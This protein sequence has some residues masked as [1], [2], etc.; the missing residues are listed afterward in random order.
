MFLSDKTISWDE[1]IAIGNAI[2]ANHFIDF[3]DIDSLLSFGETKARL[4]YLQSFL[5]VRYLISMYGPEIIHTILRSVAAGDSFHNVFIQT[6]GRDLID[7]EYDVYQEISENYR[8]M[9]VLQF[10]NIF[11]I[12]MVLLVLFVFIVIKLRNRKKIKGW[13]LVEEE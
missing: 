11:W 8:W 6:T 10:S 5:A 13:D 12:I 7:F 1:G 3:Q 4:A 9:S 2:V